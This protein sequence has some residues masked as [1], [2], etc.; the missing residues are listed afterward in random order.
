MNKKETINLILEYFKA[1]DATWF[2]IKIEQFKMITDINHLYHNM[3]LLD[4]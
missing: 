1:M 2:Q 3:W 4:L